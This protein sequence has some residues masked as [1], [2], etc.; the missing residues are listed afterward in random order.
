MTSVSFSLWQ[1]QC[2]EPAGPRVAGQHV[3]GKG[4]WPVNFYTEGCEIVCLNPTGR[5]RFDVILPRT[6]LVTNEL[7][8]LHEDQG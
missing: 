8:I 1:Y 3:S 5:I 6:C 2:V 7:P 4:M